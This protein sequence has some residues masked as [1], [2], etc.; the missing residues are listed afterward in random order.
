MKYQVDDI[1]I[2]FDSEKPGLDGKRIYDGLHIQKQVDGRWID[3][4]ETFDWFEARIFSEDSIL[5]GFPAGSFDQIFHPN[6]FDVAESVYKDMDE[7]RHKYAKALEEHPPRMPPKR[8]VL[9]KF[10]PRPG[11][12]GVVLSVREIYRNDDFSDESSLCLRYFPVKTKVPKSK[13]FHVS[14]FATWDVVM[15]D[16]SEEGANFRKR[17][18]I[19]SKKK[20]SKA[21]AQRDMYKGIYNDKIVPMNRHKEAT[22]EE[23]EEDREDDD[24]EDEEENGFYF[25]DVSMK[26]ESI[27]DRTGS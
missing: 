26:N 15:H 7:A 8:W 16:A 9:L 17:G 25:D 21:A 6:A 4:Q 14:W 1:A 19:V 2:F 20:K 22:Q 11:Q 12:K 27:P 24:V 3:F 5:L 23:D 13:R 10:P 18:K